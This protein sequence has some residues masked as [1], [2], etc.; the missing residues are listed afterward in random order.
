MKSPNLNIDGS[1]LRT[2]LD[3]DTLSMLF[4]FDSEKLL[5]DVMLS[6]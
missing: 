5:S 3:Y 6:V 4:W 2:C 1:D